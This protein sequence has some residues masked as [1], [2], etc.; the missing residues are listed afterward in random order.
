MLFLTA[1]CHQ[2]FENAKKMSIADAFG[3]QSSFT[4]F[5]SQI[6]GMFGDTKKSED[7]INLLNEIPPPEDWVA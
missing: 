2:D 6:M 5:I 7:I 4:R 1:V 3:L